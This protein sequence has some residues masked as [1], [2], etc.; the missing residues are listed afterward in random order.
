MG[1]Q[2]VTFTDLQAWCGLYRVQLTGWEL[3]TLLQMDNAYLAA[4]QRKPNE[5]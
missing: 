3:D 4:T 1:A 2:A 5:P